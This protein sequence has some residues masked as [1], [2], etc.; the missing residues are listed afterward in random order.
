MK[1]LY[2]YDQ[3]QLPFN[4][5]G[6][7][8]GR[9]FGT[10]TSAFELFVLKRKIMGPCWLNIQ[11]PEFSDKAV[12]LAQESAGPYL[13]RKLTRSTNRSRGASWKSTS[14]IPRRSSPSPK[15]TNLHPR[16]CRP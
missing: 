11:E 2:S 14:A 12:C 8:F 10:N 1:V 3:P 15:M 6:K 9:V 7:T 5:S 4:C 16:T 13:E